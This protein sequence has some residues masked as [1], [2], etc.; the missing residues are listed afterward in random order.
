MPALG[1]RAEE[2]IAL[3]PQR[4]YCLFYFLPRKLDVTDFAEG[5]INGIEWNA[6][7]GGPDEGARRDDDVRQIRRRLDPLAVNDQVFAVFDRFR[8]VTVRSQPTAIGIERNRVVDLF[9]E[10]YARI[11]A[12]HHHGRPG[13]A[14]VLAREQPIDVIG[15]VLA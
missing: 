7:I 4:I 2:A 6:I 1:S 10:R 14:S 3:L 15:A 8:Q 12:K 9:V 11:G 5:G 13:L